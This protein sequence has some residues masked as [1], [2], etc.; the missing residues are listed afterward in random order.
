LFLTKPLAVIVIV[1]LLFV[2]LCQAAESKPASQTD[3]EKVIAA[4]RKEGEVRLWG[5][6]EITHPDI[7][8]AFAKEYPSIKAVRE[9]PGWRVNAAHHRRTE[10]GQVSGGSL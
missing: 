3:W 1:W 7:V 6:Q 8:A 9:R 4:A 10:G 5:D 2:S